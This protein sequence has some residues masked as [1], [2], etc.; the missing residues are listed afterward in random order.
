MDTLER[1]D[2]IGKIARS[3]FKYMNRE[4]T[5]KYNRYLS[6]K[7]PVS[8]RYM[9]DI[10]LLLCSSD[11]IGTG[12]LVPSTSF[13]PESVIGDTFSRDLSGDLSNTSR[14]N[15]ETPEHGVYL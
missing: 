14:P 8:Y 5:V 3:E 6:T 11:C 2:R 10:S 13:K 15:L 1:V 12:G 4:K 7:I 9:G